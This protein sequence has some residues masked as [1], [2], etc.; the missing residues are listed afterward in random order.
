MLSHVGWGLGLWDYLAILFYAV[1]FV[2]P[3]ILF[4][5]S[6]HKLFERMSECSRAMEPNMVWLL[7][8]PVFN[9]GWFIHTV[10]KLRKSLYLEFLARGWDE[11]RDYGYRMGV[12]AGV[13][14]ICLVVLGWVPFVGW[15]L[16]V[17]TLVCWGL[18]WIRMASYSSRMRDAG[19]VSEHPVSPP[20]FMG[21][22]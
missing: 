11:G 13:L 3:G 18:Y 2:L 15:L 8:I 5:L 6:L 20:P 9:L 7:L 21:E 14:A 12:A 1:I 10:G 16:G 22:S 17:A 19:A 4:V